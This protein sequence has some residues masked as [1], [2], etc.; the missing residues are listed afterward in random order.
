[1]K[2]KQE[3]SIQLLY[4]ILVYI[5]FFSLSC[6]FEPKSK[7]AFAKTEKTEKQVEN[8]KNDSITIN[9]LDNAA[10][11]VAGMSVDSNSSFYELTKTKDWEIHS[12]K[13]NL[14]WQKFDSVKIKRLEKWR[15]SEI[16]FTDTISTVFYPFSG[17]DF[18]Y[19]NSFYPNA[20]KIFMFGLE[21]VGTYPTLSKF[22][23]DSLGQLFE[24]Y[25]VAISDIAKLSFFRTIDMN[26]ELSD[27]HLDGTTSIIMLFLARSN[28]EVIDIRK[29]NLDEKGEMLYVQNFADTVN[30]SIEISFRNKKGGKIRKVYYL[31]SNLSDYHLKDNQKLKKFILNMGNNRATLVK[32]ASYLMHKTYFS[33]IRNIILSKSNLI[34]QD[35]SGIPYSYLDNQK[36]QVDLYGRYENPIDLFENFYQE[37]LFSAYQNGKKGHLNFI[38]GYG[39]F[40]NLLIAKKN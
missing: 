18:I 33:T 8:K 28:M 4:R 37:D 21:N 16:K 19:A 12:S 15:A 34:I 11:F 2:K 27:D 23:R 40:S 10:R 5:L 22:N 38:I 14:L 24:L 32:S 7:E 3:K 35:D 1:M 26:T 17:P 13:I 6:S 31:S 20:E 36:W 39:N 9:E 25:H 30:Q 29:F